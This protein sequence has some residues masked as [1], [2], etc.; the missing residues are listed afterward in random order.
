MTSTFVASDASATPQG[1]RTSTQYLDRPSSTKTARS[2]ETP[3][4]QH[5]LRSIS[6][7]SVQ[8]RRR[9]APRPPGGA[10]FGTLEGGPLFPTPDSWILLSMSREGVAPS[11]PASDTGMRLLHHRDVGPGNRGQETGVS[12]SRLPLPS[13]GGTPDQPSRARKPGRGAAEALCLGTGYRVL[14][15]LVRD[16]G[17]APGL[18]LLPKQV[19]RCLPMS[20][21][22]SAAERSRTSNTPRLRRRRLP[23][24][25]QPRMFGAR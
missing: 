6:G 16:P 13:P 1:D 20:L 10:S 4:H 9:D 25:P 17:L 5:P 19:G 23:V 8:R 11:P 24:A 12:P 14:V 15:R 18:C 3:L 21:K 22:G 2:A 7:G